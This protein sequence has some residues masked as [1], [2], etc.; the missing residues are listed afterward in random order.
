MTELEKKVLACVKRISR[1]SLCFASDYYDK[2]KLTD[3]MSKEVFVDHLESLCEQGELVKVVESHGK[4]TH[5]GYILPNE[6]F[7]GFTLTMGDDEQAKVAMRIV[8]KELTYA[9]SW[10]ENVKRK[11]RVI[12][13]DT[14]SYIGLIQE[15]K[16]TSF[17]QEI[18]RKHPD[19]SFEITSVQCISNSIPKERAFYEG[20]GK[21]ADQKYEY[22]VKFSIPDVNEYGRISGRMS[23][24][25]ITT[26][27][28]V[29][30]V[31][32]FPTEETL[33]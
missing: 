20:Y 18:A 24:T 16:I 17:C 23:G 2:S 28:I 3:S 10:K 1:G 9:P 12:S 8:K 31:M 25:S 5:T 11:G 29:N 21:F 32:W 22:R 14:S 15:D 4:F 33:E 26:N 27:K 30:G 13:V 19:F 7:G 6:C